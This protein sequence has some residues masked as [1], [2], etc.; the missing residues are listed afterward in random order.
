MSS[1][2]RLDH[3]RRMNDVDTVDRALA[4]VDDLRRENAEL[5]AQARV[6]A[7]LGP[8]VEALMRRLDDAERERDAPRPRTVKEKACARCGVMYR[9]RGGRSTR[10]DPCADAHRAEYRVAYDAARQLKVKGEG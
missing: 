5:R 6:L 3:L 1:P 4:I 10:C 7:I 8:L 2:V 9:P